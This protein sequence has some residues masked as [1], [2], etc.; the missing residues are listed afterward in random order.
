MKGFLLCMLLCYCV[1]E[2]SAQEITA[3]L[4]GKFPLKAER[5]IGI[6]TYGNRY[7]VN[8]NTLVKTSENKTY[9]FSDRQL[10][11]L[12]SVDILNPLKIV[13]FYRNIIP[14]CCS[15][16]SSVKSRV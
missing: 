13:L 6:D 1:W 5:F 10:G 15:M 9:Q 2:A 4:A 8:H 3:T 11:H 14:R 16:T 12:S 7:V